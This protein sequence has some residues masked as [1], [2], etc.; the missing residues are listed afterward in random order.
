MKYRALINRFCLF[1]ALIAVCSSPLFAQTPRVLIVGD[2]WAAQQVADNVHQVVFTA[3]GFSQFTVDG[4]NTAISGSEAADWAM[5]DQ[6]ALIAEA[7]DAEPSI[8]TVQLTIGGN[9]FLGA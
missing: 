9:D 1:I 6:L 4:A 8:D 2:S 5:A 7:L 3:N